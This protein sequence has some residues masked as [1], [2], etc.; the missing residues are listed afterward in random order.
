MQRDRRRCA[1]ACRRGASAAG[2]HRS[3]R[4]SVFVGL[5]IAAAGR[6]AFLA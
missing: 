5:R 4:D 2:G 1:D 3:Q 6:G